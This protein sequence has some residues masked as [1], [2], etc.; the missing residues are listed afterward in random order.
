M[1]KKLLAIAV[2]AAMVAPMVAQAV[3]TTISGSAR[4]RAIDIHKADDT[5]KDTNFEQKKYYDQRVRIKIDAKL[6][7]KDAGKG[8]DPTGTAV[9]TRFTISDGKFDATRNTRKQHPTE[10]DASGVLTDYAYLSVPIGPGTLN[11]GLQLA[12]WGNAMM[13]W[14]VKKDRIKYTLPLAGGMKVVLFTDKVLEASDTDKEEG[15]DY[16]TMAAAF[17]APVMGGKAGLLYVNQNKRDGD[18]DHKT[19]KVNGTEAKKGVSGSTID[20]FLNGKIGNIGLMAEFVSKSGEVNETGNGEQKA[21]KAF[22]VAATLPIGAMSLTVAGIS[23]DRFAVD[24]DFVTGSMFSQFDGDANIHGTWGTGMDKTTGLVASLTLPAGPGKVSVNL[25]LGNY[26]MNDADADD[27]ENQGS[28]QALEVQYNMNV[29]S[30]TTV[31]AFYGLTKFT[32]EYDEDNQ[33]LKDLKDSTH[34]AMGAKIQV[35]F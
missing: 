15:M 35:K 21:P 16:D 31:K 23:T 18:S 17:I 28:I 3:D 20:V 34:K 5:D 11:A 33:T 10:A 19:G 24:D 2:A 12:S 1:N 7:K 14:A 22:F 4:V 8:I 27:K 32:S 9:H 29:N 30:A 6:T 26:D 13:T 25:G